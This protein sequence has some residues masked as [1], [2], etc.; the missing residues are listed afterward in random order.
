[1]L[2]SPAFEARPLLVVALGGNALSPPHGD[3]ERY[4][5]ERQRTAETGRAL[6]ALAADHY[7]LLIV[8]GNGPQVGRLLRHDPLHA[9]LDVH[10]AQT[11]GELGYLLARSIDAPTVCLLTRVI[12]A[13]DHG[14][15]VKPIGPILAAKPQ[16]VSSVAVRR[17]WRVTVPSPKPA[18]IVEHEVIASLVRARHVIAG[19]GGGVALTQ[20]G[21]PVDAVV[22]KDRIAS[23]L[24]VA[25]DAAHLVFATDV[26]GVYA[27]FGAPDARA[28][29]ELS[30]AEARRM[31]SSGQAA[32]G[33]MA[34]KL[35]SAA[36]FACSTRRIAHICSL[37]GIR[38]ALQTRGGTAVVGPD[39]V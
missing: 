39:A 2:S 29:P 25:L 21:A 33:S 30:V 19:G 12:V 26:D 27:N 37:D 35:E 6:S 4:D 5:A 32:S 13:E 14:V 28:L 24:A 31:V 9:N 10:V 22:D 34:P 11:Q 15:P 8:H 7:R 36:E 18:R 23:L 3:L 38:A 1:M 17:G 16:S 20:T